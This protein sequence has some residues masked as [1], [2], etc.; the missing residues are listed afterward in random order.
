MKKA[1]KAERLIK[2]ID[3]VG[4]VKVEQTVGMPQII[5]SYNYS[6]LA[7]YGL[8]VKEVNRTI[9]SAFA[10]ETAG[11]VYEGEKRFDLVVRLQSDY[12]NNINDVRNLYIT[13]AS[14]A[15]IPLEEVAKVDLVDAPMQISR[16]NTNR[17]I[18][19]GVNVGNTDVETLADK[20]ER[21]LDEEIILPA[22]YYFTY[23]G[24][25]ENL[26]AANARLSIAVPLALALIFIL[27]Y[28]TFRSIPQALLIFTAIP[29]SAIGGIWALQLRGMPFSISAGIGF[30]ALFGVAVLNGIVLI[31]YLNQLKKEGM[32]NIKD[33][34]RKGTK[35][36]IETGSFNGFR[37][38][39]RLFTNGNFKIR[40]CRGTTTFGDGCNWRAYICNFFNAYCSSCPL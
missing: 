40:W 32:T 14:G 25:F 33:R 23:G 8:Q 27:L 1:K 17:K 39:I 16:E 21:T 29:L 26:K 24:Q 3:G 4:T 13:L 19:I 7:Q 30:I 35:V 11:T 5:I 9:R 36:R 6:K 18:V 28:L 31:G 22:G 38:I 2:S 12:R 37:S 34:I 10:G 15:Q 20:I